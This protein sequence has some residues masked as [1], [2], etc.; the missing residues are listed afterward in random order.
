MFCDRSHSQAKRVPFSSRVRALVP[1]RDMKFEIQIST[2]CITFPVANVWRWINFW[3]SVVHLQHID[4]EFSQTVDKSER[5]TGVLDSPSPTSCSPPP[6]QTFRT[7][8]L[9]IAMATFGAKYFANQQKSVSG[10]FG[11]TSGVSSISSRG[12]WLFNPE[13]AGNRAYL[14]RGGG[15]RGGGEGE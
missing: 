10:L 15:G 7:V 8:S 12:V 13:P 9:T 2:C 11:I 6:P 4:E 5:T 14:W 1:A 3:T